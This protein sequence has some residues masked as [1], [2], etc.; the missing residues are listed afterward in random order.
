MSNKSKYMLAAIIA[1]GMSPLATPAFATD[2]PPLATF[3]SS[4][5]DSGQT[6]NYMQGARENSQGQ[7]EESLKATTPVIGD[8]FDK[9]NEL[10][11]RGRFGESWLR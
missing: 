2:G 7:V 5:Q 6:Y 3:L 8:A 9:Y 10:T 11:D 1:L 4:T